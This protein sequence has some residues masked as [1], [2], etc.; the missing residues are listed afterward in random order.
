MPRVLSLLVFFVSIGD[1]CFSQ[2]GETPQNSG[3]GQSDSIAIPLTLQ[4]VSEKLAKIH[5]KTGGTTFIGGYILNIYH[6]SVDSADVTINI[7]G[8][9]QKV[10]YPGNSLFFANMMQSLKGKLIDISVQQPDYHA[11]D[12][13]FVVN[14]NGPSIL[15]INLVPKYKILLRGRVYSGNVPLEGVNVEIRHGD[16]KY[17]MQTRGCFY[18]KDNYWNCLYDGMFKAELT[19]DDPN[20]SINISL[21]KKGM[22]PLHV[23][24]K[25]KEYSGDVMDLKMK[26]QNRL[27]E[28]PLND[29]NL[30]LAF[31]FTS[32]GKD[33]SVG[34]SYYRTLKIKD[35]DRI[36]LGLDANALIS[37][38]EVSH[39]TFPGLKNS[40]SDSSYVTFFGGPAIQF[41]IIKPEVRKFSTYI[42]SAG[43]LQFDNKQFV[44]MPFIGTRFF[45]DMNKAFSLELRYISYNRNVIHYTF[46]P[47]GLGSAKRFSVPMHY[48]E[49]FV[50]FGIQVVF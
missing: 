3:F 15:L 32:T 28:I 24:M 30:K 1:I 18:D 45:L 42:G 8:K 2:I 47:T 40:V 33:W 12:T 35:F 48:N 37:V 27:P 34:V 22:K 38:V 9:K 7:Q 49:F 46:D 5:R 13:S 39:P 14:N 36:A 50:N 29:I 26:Y 20:D 31:P 6:E 43:T 44:A 10:L 19:T 16:K 4:Q 23:G 17:T 25:F 41:W 11:Y 21:Q